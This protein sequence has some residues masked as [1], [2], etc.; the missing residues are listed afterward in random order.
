M[1][2][3]D[4]V[5][6]AGFTRKFCDRGTLGQMLTYRS[7]QREEQ[8]MTPTI[9]SRCKFNSIADP[10]S[11][12][13]VYDPPIEEFAVITTELSPSGSSVCFDAIE[14]PSIVICTGGVGTIKVGSKQEVMTEGI[15]VFV[16]AS[17]YCELESSAEGPFVTFRAFCETSSDVKASS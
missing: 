6:R 15:V 17:M 13:V 12:A 16:A 4:N 11:T 1:A 10:S 9:Y 8:K 7:T 5:V 14:G 3:S 2:T